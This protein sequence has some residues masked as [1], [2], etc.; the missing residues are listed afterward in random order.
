VKSA[1]RTWCYWDD[2]RLRA[3]LL[4]DPAAIFSATDTP[5]VRALKQEVLDRRA[6]TGRAFPKLLGIMIGGLIISAVVGVID[7]AIRGIK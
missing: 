2:W 1:G 4:R 7:Y 3:R 6:D 5:S